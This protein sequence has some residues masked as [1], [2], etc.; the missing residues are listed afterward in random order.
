MYTIV[1][2][3][4]C[5]RCLSPVVTVPD[6]GDRVR[7]DPSLPDSIVTN[8]PS[9]P[10]MESRDAAAASVICAAPR[11]ATVNPLTR[12]SWT[13]QRPL[14]GAVWDACDRVRGRIQP[15]FFRV[16]EAQ[17]S[18]PANS[19][20]DVDHSDAY[21]K[22]EHLRGMVSVTVDM[23]GW[24]DVNVS[25]Q[26]PGMLCI[27]THP[28][29]LIDA[30]HSDEFLA[31]LWKTTKAWPHPPEVPAVGRHVHGI[32]SDRIVRILNVIGVRL[33]RIVIFGTRETLAEAHE[34]LVKAHK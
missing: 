26:Y 1:C 25:A 28:L 34:R 3:Y 13:P 20:F 7:N 29:V 21:F 2:M 5:E 8:D 14:N 6:A 11:P 30:K 17:R 9:P 19:T 27:S 16:L 24:L 23:P 22:L 4:V 33:F 15:R 12:P 10:P 31:E 32:P 18:D